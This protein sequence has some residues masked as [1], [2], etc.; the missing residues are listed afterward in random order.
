MYFFVPESSNGKDKITQTPVLLAVCSSEGNIC[1]NLKRIKSKT[2]FEVLLRRSQR[3]QNLGF[4]KPYCS[5][6]V[7]YQP[8]VSILQKQTLPAVMP[9]ILEIT[10]PASKGLQKFSQI[11]LKSRFFFTVTYCQPSLRLHIVPMTIEIYRNIDMFIQRFYI[12]TQNHIWFGLEGMFIN[13][14]FRSP[15]YRQG[16]LPL[17]QIAQS[18]IQPG[19]E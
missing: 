10:L 13:T 11:L 14:Q 7:Q 4:Y 17:D 16:H 18:H 5:A 8:K 15:C 6:S 12:E 9:Q 3:I 2:I 1:I 19:L